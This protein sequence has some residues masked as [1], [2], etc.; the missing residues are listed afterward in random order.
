MRPPQR[1]GSLVASL[2]LV[3]GAAAFWLA[4]AF[5][6][7]FAIPQYVRH[8]ADL[9]QDVDAGSVAAFLLG[10]SAVIAIV[11][12][13]I[14]VLL[15]WLDAYGWSAARVLTYVYS[16]LSAVVAVALVVSHPFSGIV[17]HD[18]LM[19][20]TTVLTLLLLAGAIVMLMRP[21]SRQ[22]F[23]DYSAIR[24]EAA[25]QRRAARLQQ[26]QRFRPPYPPQPP[27]Q[28]MPYPPASAVPPAPPPP[29]PTAEPPQH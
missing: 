19:T 20:A 7:L 17:W 29:S 16:G 2:Y 3:G 9:D 11:G 23:R 26:M 18:R 6:T 15:V 25:N 12:A 21:A 1:P 8:Y 14:A 5:A 13:A 24:Q 28:R 27:Q 22:F 4:A 10:L